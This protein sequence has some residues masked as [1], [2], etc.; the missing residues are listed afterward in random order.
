MTLPM[1]ISSTDSILT[2]DLASASLTAMTPRAGAER[3]ASEPSLAPMGVREALRMK[4]GLVDWG[5]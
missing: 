2:P 3:D 1:K 4:V 5:C